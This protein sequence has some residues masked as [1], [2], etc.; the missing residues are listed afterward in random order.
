MLSAVA[1]TVDAARVAPDVEHLSDH[2]LTAWTACL[3][4]IASNP[5][6]RFGVYVDRTIPIFGFPMRTWVYEIAQE[7]S[8]SGE[9]IYVFYGEFFPE[10]APVYV[11]D[12]RANEVVVLFLRAN[13]R[14]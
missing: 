8:I 10:Y 14:A 2:A 1:F 3:A 4:E 12:E 13:R 11:V 9:P 5:Y 6:S 7:T